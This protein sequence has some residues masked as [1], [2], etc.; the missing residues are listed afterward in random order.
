MQLM[1][2]HQLFRLGHGFNSYKL[3]LPGRV[4]LWIN[5]LDPLGILCPAICG[6]D[7]ESSKVVK[8]APK[9]DN[10]YTVYPAAIM[11]GYSP[12]SPPVWTLQALGAS[13]LRL[14]SYIPG[15]VLCFL[16][17]SQRFAASNPR[18][19][20]WYVMECNGM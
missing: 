7:L 15:G 4:S 12:G 14:V 20:Q 6:C 3:T 17:A 5:E 10:S 13:V 9:L 16:L 18:K 8:K 11:K 1:D 19:A 2:S